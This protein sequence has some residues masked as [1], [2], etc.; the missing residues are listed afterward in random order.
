[1]R[2]TAEQQT[3]MYDQPDEEEFECEGH[4]DGPVMGETFYCDGA[5]I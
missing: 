1:M 3:A 4:A 2:D 5:C